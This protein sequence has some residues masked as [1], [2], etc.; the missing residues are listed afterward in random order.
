V[1]GVDTNGA[2]S[3][4]ARASARREALLSAHSTIMEVP[5]YE[6]I[7]AVEYR[8][9][10]YAEGRKI[11]AKH[12]RQRDEATRELYTAADQLIAASINSFDLTEGQ[13]RELNLSWGLALAK[14]LGVDAEGMTARQATMACFA[15]DTLL[16]RHWAEYIEWLS[17]AETDVDEEQ[18]AD[19]RS[20]ISPSSPT[21]P[22]SSASPST[23]SL[24]T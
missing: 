19:F 12:E 1:K 24:S 7:L 6:G 5:G 18:A 3:L 17:S 10:D 14:M 20:T 16:T 23:P 4:A 13:P 11:G 8:A 15:R 22:P 21:T 2:G 9:M